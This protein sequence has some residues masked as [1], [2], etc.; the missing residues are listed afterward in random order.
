MSHFG[1]ENVSILGLYHYSDSLLEKYTPFIL[2]M[3]ISQ[4]MLYCIEYVDTR[5][6]HHVLGRFIGHPTPNTQYMTSNPF[7]DRPN[8][9]LVN[10]SYTLYQD[11][12]RSSDFT[13]GK[14]MILV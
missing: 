5:H 4:N 2:L 7:S 12:G 6:F 8:D 1:P 11:Y 3:Q 14:L 13:A 9:F 10:L